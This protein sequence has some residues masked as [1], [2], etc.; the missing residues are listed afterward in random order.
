M[1]KVVIDTFDQCI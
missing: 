1:I